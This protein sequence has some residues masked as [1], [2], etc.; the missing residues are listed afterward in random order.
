MKVLKLLLWAFVIVIVVYAIY[1]AYKDIAKN[2]PSESRK[3]EKFQEPALKV[4]LF[5]AVWCPH[6][7][8]YLDSKVFMSTYDDLKKKSKFDK[9][10]FVQFDFD[11]NKE[12]ADKYSISSF[13]TII[14]ISSDGTLVNQFNG[15]R[16]SKSD[17]EDFVNESLKK[18]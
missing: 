13:P 18:L 9:V 3:V 2:I 12:L 4:C 16:N 8:H 7:E 5:Y 14:A 1:M 17:L 15:D 6:C 10:V 11:K